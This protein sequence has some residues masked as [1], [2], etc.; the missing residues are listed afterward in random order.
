[1]P[2]DH[3]V[4]GR[5]KDTDASYVASRTLEE[6]VTVLSEEDKNDYLRF[7]LRM[8][9][10]MPEDRATAEDLLSDSWLFL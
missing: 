8:L 7:V 3:D 10:W 1:M 4:A 5:L 2:A 9:Q 6:T